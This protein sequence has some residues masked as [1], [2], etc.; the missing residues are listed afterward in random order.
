MD[1]PIKETQWKTASRT[2]NRI[3]K[4]LSRTMGKCAPGHQASSQSMLGPWRRGG[5]AAGPFLFPATSKSR[6]P[7]GSAPGLQAMGLRTVLSATALSNV[8]KLR[9]WRPGA[10]RD[11]QAANNST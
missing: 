4:S 7:L 5:G 2:Q 11:S 9:E 1:G 6:A 3:S 10:T 8:I